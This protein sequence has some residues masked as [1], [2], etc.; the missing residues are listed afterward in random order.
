MS[1]RN[2]PGPIV[3][4]ISTAVRRREA[5]AYA[6]LAAA[7]HAAGFPKITAGQVHEWVMAGLLPATADQRSLGRHGFETLRRPGVEDQLIALCRLRQATKSWDRLAVLLWLEGWQIATDRLRRAII[8]DLGDPSKLGLDGS[9][10]ETLDKLDQYARRQ[11]P[12]FARRAGLG[13]VG[14]TSAAEG[15]MAALSVTLGGALWDEEAA[16]A[17][18]RVAGLTRARSD[19]I[20]DAPPW[21]DGP[22]AP[23]IDLSGFAFRAPD[24]VRHATQSQLEAARPCARAFAIDVPLVVHAVELGFGLNIAGLGVLARGH[25]TPAMAVAIA[26]FFADVGFERQL[27]AMV[28]TWS[29]LAS[30]VAPMLPVVEAYVAKHPEQ[31]AAIRKDGLQ[32]LVERGEVVPLEPD[33][34]EALGVHSAS[35]SPATRATPWGGREDGAR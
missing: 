31:R 13:H 34:L 29:G 12:R 17:I 23:S 18:E 22:A 27:S 19:S 9:N 25:I 14:P 32:A 6:E 2:S 8:E 28:E 21:L 11:G 30:Q 33:E 1:V 3:Q 7:A 16:Q 10:D 15:V 26:L 5:V 4:R 24:L 20:G 35:A